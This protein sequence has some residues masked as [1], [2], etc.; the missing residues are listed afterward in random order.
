MEKRRADDTGGA[1]K[2]YDIDYYVPRATVSM[3]DPIVAV[4]ILGIE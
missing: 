4:K 3:G 2:G 1:I